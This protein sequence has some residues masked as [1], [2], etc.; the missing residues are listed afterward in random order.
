MRLSKLNEIQIINNISKLIKTSEDVKIGIGDDT[1][2]IKWDKNK[3]LLF[4]TD[5]L[6]EDV[7]FKLDLDLDKSLFEKIGRKS[8]AVNLSDIAAM[9]G[10][11]RYAVVSIGISKD[12]EYEFL[13]RIYK[14]IE[15][16]A[17]QFDVKVVG[18]DINS[19]DKLLINITLIGE[20]S[21][22]KLILRSSANAGDS[23]FITGKLGGSIYSKHLNFTPL[24]E[25]SHILNNKF[26]ITSMIDVSDGLIYDAFRLAL[27]SRVKLFLYSKKVPLSDKAKSLD[28]ALY[29]GEDFEL[30]FTVDE[31]SA[32]K[33]DANLDIL[34]KTPL[35]NIGYIERGKP[36]VVLIDE[37]SRRISAK[38]DG[39]DHFGKS[40]K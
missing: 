12:F 20:V 16:L 5:M 4:T 21:H 26:K 28:N 9:G 11:P 32:N 23:V 15:T 33:L 35:T 36:E 17:A 13:K 38:M 1:A 18:G 22:G 34:G 3:F 25:E 37:K 31:K 19:S 2:V 29:D 40:N 39:Y 27:A 6:L 8:L 10:I 7:H 30:L 24:I 14:G